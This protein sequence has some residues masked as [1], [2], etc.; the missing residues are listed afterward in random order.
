MGER[1][2]KSLS[3]TDR[4]I[5]ARYFMTANQNFERSNHEKGLDRI[6]VEPC[7]GLQSWMNYLIDRPVTDGFIS[8][9]PGQSSAIGREGDRIIPLQIA[10]L[11]K[12]SSVPKSDTTILASSGQ[13]FTVRTESDLADSGRLRLQNPR[14]FP[15]LQTPEDDLCN[16]VRFAESRAITGGD[17]QSP[18][19]GRNGQGENLERIARPSAGWQIVKRREIE[20]RRMNSLVFERPELH[21]PIRS[22]TGEDLAAGT[23]GNRPNILAVIFY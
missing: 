14:L 17:R 7:D 3:A 19:I 11:I 21:D 10:N 5:S 22:A 16:S 20:G 8:S 15:V 13:Q 1:R 12:T 18:A 23:K 4:R 9:L 2:T 6:H